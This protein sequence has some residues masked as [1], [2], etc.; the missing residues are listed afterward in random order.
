M[1]IRHKLMFKYILTIALCLIATPGLTQQTKSTLNAEIST[2]FPNNTTGQITPAKLRSTLNNI[3]NSYYDLNGSSAI[4]CAVN[5]WVVGMPTLSSLSCAQPSVSSISGFGTGVVT[6]LGINI[7][8]V[9]GLLLNGATA[10]GDLTGTYPNPI[11]AT[12]NSNIGSFGSSTNCVTITVNAKGLITAASETACAGGG[13]GTPGGSSGQIQYNNAGAFGGFT[14]SGDATI[15]TGTGAL[16]LA[17]VNGN[18]GAFGS[19][20]SCITTTA[21]AKGLITAIS[22]ATCTPAI[23]SI[24][25]LGT[26]IATAL[27]VNVGSA[28]A[29][30]LFNGAGGTPSSLTGT[31]ITGTA[32]GL[33]AGTASAVAVGGITGLSANCGTWLATASSA[34]LRSCMTDE[35]GTGVLY[36]Q[37]GDAGTPSALVGTNI[38]GTAASLTVGNATK[39]ATARAIGIAGSTGLTATGVNFDGTAAIDPA[40]T[41]TLAVANGGTGETGTAWSTTSS[42][43]PAGTACT[44]TATGRHKILGNKTVFY[45]YDVTVAS[46]TCT[47]NTN[48]TMNLP[49]AAQSGAGTAA[50]ENIQ[51]GGTFVF[52]IILSSGT[53]ITC[54]SNQA[55][56]TTA[57]FNISGV[58]ERQ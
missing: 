11:L 35:T 8:A 5:Q 48:I 47:V 53:I 18:V 15:N 28:G 46:G 30:V 6:A 55:L 52:C 37:G 22:A 38:S 24:T 20:T 41:G 44:L 49:D 33:T 21:N 4:T 9:G 1:H 16:T 31:N 34:N 26:G 29:P 58:Y 23:G 51:G 56:A 36:F 10:G 25:G 32:A 57:H 17:T 12:V 40:L 13:G 54:R 3:V 45:Q 14:A 27:A 42:I 7:G 43:S 2:N 50:M 39:L 19:A